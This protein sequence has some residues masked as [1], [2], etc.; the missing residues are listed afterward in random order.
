MAREVFSAL[1]GL[2]KTD[3]ISAAALVMLGH[4]RIPGNSRNPLALLLSSEGR[5]AVASAATPTYNMC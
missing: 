2:V 5:W 4:S 1:L 3:P